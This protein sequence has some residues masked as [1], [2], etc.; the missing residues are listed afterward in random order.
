MEPSFYSLFTRS[1]YLKD[2]VDNDDQESEIRQRKR[3]EAE[4]FAVMGIGFC[5]KHAGQAF[6]E[7]FLKCI[8]LPGFL[9][10]NERGIR[11]E[12][13][14]WGD[15][16]LV[17]SDGT[18]VCVVECKIRAKLEP[19]QNP[20]ENAFWADGGYGTE[21]E[22]TFRGR[23][24]F[25]VVLGAERELSPRRD[26][27]ITTVQ[28]YWKDLDD[29]YPHTMPLAADLYQALAD[30]GVGRFKLRHTR[31]MKLGKNSQHAAKAYG[32]LEGAYIRLNLAEWKFRPDIVYKNETD[33][34]FGLEIRR[35]DRAS[36][37]TGP[38]GKLQSLVAPVDST[39]DGLAISKRTKIQVLFC[40]YGFIQVRGQRKE[41]SLRNCVQMQK[42]FAI[43]LRP[44]VTTNSMLSCQYMIFRSKIAANKTGL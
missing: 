19:H 12:D 42:L 9:F 31:Y 25:Y 7:H 44:E 24:I 38:H 35:S 32:I 11:V 15:L 10:A 5:L 14:R 16:V 34:Y 20:E 17:S 22:R 39:L 43:P 6:R 23:R 37:E 2:L 8:E 26:H 29:G 36:D 30:L 4:R 40:V 3:R 13:K 18:K 1:R 41:M 28:K 33:W 27:R 21:I